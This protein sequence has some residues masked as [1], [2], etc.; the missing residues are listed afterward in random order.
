MATGG[1]DEKV[2]GWL[3]HTSATD[4]NFKGALERANVATI[5][6]ALAEVVGKPGHKV[7]EK[8]LQAQLQKLSREH[9]EQASEAATDLVQVEQSREQLAKTE[10]QDR[11]RRLAECHQFIGRIQAVDMVGKLATVSTLMWLKD[12]KESKLYRDLPGI[13]T[14]DK[15][16]ESLGKSRRLIDEQLLNLDAFG[17]EFLETV[18]SLRVGYR[19]MK[20]LRQLTHDGALQIE[21]GVLVVGG[22]EIPLDDRDELQAAMERLLDAKEQ[23]IAEKDATIRTKDKLLKSKDDLI[24]RQEKE[25]ARF[26]GT[27][28]GK[29]LTAEEDALIRKFTNAKTSFDGFLL[30][31]DPDRNPLPEDATPRMKA[32][33]METLG[34]FRRAIVAAH[35]TAGD[36]YGDAEMDSPGWVQPNLRVAGQEG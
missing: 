11:E 5:Q 34:Y 23:V 33:Y 22:E 30:Q 28:A 20:R 24:H 1:I 15:F 7:R 8:A 26:E 17:A 4:I 32:V 2:K 31:F 12:V 21:D 27:A 36:L 9:A 3:V 18:S 10:Q 6:A 14:W 19:E 35:D 16:C 13:E 29:G 25:I